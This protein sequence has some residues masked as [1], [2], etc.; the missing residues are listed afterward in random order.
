MFKG[1]FYGIAAAGSMLLAG[2]GGAYDSAN[3][4][5]DGG[6]QAADAHGGDHAAAK[7]VFDRALLDAEGRPEGDKAQDEGRNALGVYE[8]LGVRP[9]MTVAD[10]FCS[11]GY[12]THL[13]SQA[14]G[15][16]GE[17]YAV[18]EFYADKDAY[19]GRLYK[20]DAVEERVATG[21]LENVSLAES[22]A[23]VPDES[24]D[25]ALAVRN[26]HDIEWVFQH[27]KR[28]DF[29]SSLMAKMKPGGVVGIVEAATHHE[30][31]HDET[32]RLNEQV[33][34]DDFTGAGFELVESSDLL[35]D[36]EDDHGGSGFEEGRYNQDRYLLKFQKPSV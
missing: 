9:G 30:G 2:C 17:V 13:L 15:D 5:H 35:A 16:E 25:V 18:F 3:G 8:F 33:V 7:H 28:A 10:V 6:E 11:G 12:N 36:P 14:V 22:L 4:A 29:L 34:I 19:G 1:K 31:W 24:L 23:D 20:V 21:G 32:H 26:Y 27:L